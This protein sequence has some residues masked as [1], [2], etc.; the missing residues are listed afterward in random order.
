MFDAF[1]I[2]SFGSALLQP[3]MG[4]NDACN[5]SPLSLID[6]SSSRRSTRG[7]TS[8]PAQSVAEGTSRGNRYQ[9][10]REPRIDL[11]IVWM[12]HYHPVDIAEKLKRPQVLRDITQNPDAPQC[13]DRIVG[14][15]TRQY[16]VATS[17]RAVDSCLA[18]TTSTQSD[19]L[20]Q[21]CTD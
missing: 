8:S 11:V 1:Q 15:I 19:C 7:A 20:V 3:I 13:Y 10:A 2:N 6:L 4:R 9:N 21:I 14:C 18:S 17:L 12:E 5:P 16:D